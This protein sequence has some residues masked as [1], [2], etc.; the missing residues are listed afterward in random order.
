[1]APLSYWH[2]S[3]RAATTWPRGRRCPATSTSTSPSSAPASPGSGPRTTLLRADPDAAGRRARAGG[4]RLR[5]LGPQRR[6]VRRRPRRPRRCRREGRGR[7][8]GRARW[9]GRCTAPSTRSAPS[10]RREGIDCG[11]HKGGAIYFAVNQGQLRA[12][13]RLPRA[14]TSTYG[15]GDAWHA[16]RR[17][18]GGG[19]RRCPRHPRRH[20]H[21]ARGGRPPG[22]PRPRAGRR[23][24]AARRGD[25]RGDRG[26]VRSSSAAVRTEH[27]TVRAEVV[28]RATE[29][30]TAE[31]RGPGARRCC[32]SATTW[33]P[34][35]PSTSDVWAEIGLA[36]RELFEDIATTARLRPAHRGRTASPGAA[37][38]LRPGGSRASRRRR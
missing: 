29:A 18:A 24:R 23:G 6:L 17:R 13:P 35:S 20:V 11:F 34:P 19:D 38:A 14:T 3:L 7:G 12:G 15:L 37:S 2:D 9:S 32:R 8:R 30:Y 33:S 16:A 21:A 4:R 10:S 28:V 25:P 36:N 27:G 1:M 22:P 31:H 26:P 5:C